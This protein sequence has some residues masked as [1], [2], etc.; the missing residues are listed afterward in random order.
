MKKQLKEKLRLIYGDEGDCCFERLSSLMDQYKDKRHYAHHLSQKDVMMI[1]YGDSL[2]DDKK[3]PLVALNDFL[4][5]YVKDD[6]SGVHILPFYP[7]TSDDGFSVVDYKQVNPDLGDWN[8]I[9]ALSQ[10]YDLM[11]DAVINHI[12]ASSDWFKGYLAGEDRYK[13]YFITCDPTEDY[14]LVVRPRALPLLTPV[15][16]AAGEQHVWTTFSS[17]QIDLNYESIDVFL[18]VMSVLLDYAVSGSK[19]IRLDAIAFMW[20]KLGTTSI[21]LEETHELIKVMRMVLEEVVP[22][23]C[24]ITETNVPHHENIS[25]FGKGD[26]AH[27]V[28]QFPLPPLTLYT[29][30]A[31]DTTDISRWINGLEPT[32]QDT[33]YFN[34]L[35]SHDGIGMRPVEGLLDE[36]Q[37]GL[38]VDCVKK[39]GGKINY[40]TLSDGSKV[41][42][43][44]NI[45]YVDALTDL[46][47]DDMIRGKRFLA[48]QGVLLS[49]KG[50]PGIYVHSLLG[51]R[52]DQKG[53]E[54]SGINRRINREKL[55]LHGLFDNELR[56]QVFDG[57][58]HMLNVRKS[59][60]AFS[61]AASQRA[62]MLDKRL[63]ALE[64][65]LDTSK[66]MIV[67][68]VSNE[69]I[70]LS[71]PYDGIDLLTLS[72][73]KDV[74]EPYEVLWI[75]VE[76]E[77]V[78]FKI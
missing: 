50:V 29:F 27:M 71:L 70:P 26:E 34:F 32:P 8:D 14:S 75:K 73:P 24:L 43:E 45:S 21:H 61:P 74:I 28:Y 3:M 22:G 37:Q 38:I 9:D 16:T 51:S 31:E 62:V 40:R 39:R 2:L 60:K 47:E 52:N 58:T 63:F 23:T 49:V 30:L 53:V 54:V 72:R 67:I 13:D 33:T 4:T 5:T 68:N 20:K 41:P 25:Y 76:N 17:D 66:V 6:I 10:N 59:E 55:N 15:E 57:Y 44:L 56:R 65:V 18:E 1:T 48:S 64:R 78:S 36:N 77:H 19:Y 11:F 7:Y 46:D 12:S 42:Y 35:A 69:D